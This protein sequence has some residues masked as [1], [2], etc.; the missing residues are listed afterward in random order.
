MRNLKDKVYT[1]PDENAL[2]RILDQNSGKCAELVIRLV[3]NAGMNLT[4]A[5]E[6]KWE[7]VDFQNG[8]INL[9]GRAIPMDEGL[10]QCLQKW[11]DRYFKKSPEYVVF[12]GSYH[13]H[14]TR[15][16]LSRIV[17]AALK[18]G[19]MEGI[20]RADLRQ[21]YVIRLMEQY[22]LPYVSRISGL[23]LEVLKANYYQYVRPSTN[24][25][26]KKQ[27]DNAVD[28]DKM[29]R[30]VKAEGVPLGIAIWLAW[31]QDMS[32]E[33]MVALTWD[34]IDLDSR[35]LNLPSGYVFIDGTLEEL[36]RKAWEIREP[37]SLPYV[38][39]SPK[40]K[41]PFAKE[42]LS[43][44]MRQAL[45]RGSIDDACVADL[46]TATRCKKNEEI[47][48]QYLEKEKY[49]TIEGAK[50]LLHTSVYT[51]PYECLL[52]LREQG[53]VIRVGAKYYLAGTV[54]PPELQYET[55]YAYLTEK[56]SARLGELTE[57][58]GIE[59][60]QCMWVLTVLAKDG[61][62]LHENRKY[63]LPQ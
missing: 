42:R 44:V 13:L 26:K 40:A 24:V 3:W 10:Q 27:A 21:D 43:R 28:G 51:M 45:I 52:R 8:Q 57:L 38:L 18:A 54:V 17:S 30:L 53:K 62:L 39:L 20:S 47:I 34:Q 60:K 48:L 63:T 56:G 50:K 14:I 55:I 31:K 16:S 61:K 36:L 2:L 59:H 37:E 7:Q 29:M 58:L 6:L 12:G 19:G 33:E 11:H 32:L 15:V 4:E 35:I 9:T 25:E 5:R 22:D 1:R 23:K 46:K 41:K 49:I